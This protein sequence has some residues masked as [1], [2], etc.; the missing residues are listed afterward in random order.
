M[1][2]FVTELRSCIS[3]RSSSS[4]VT[5]QLLTLSLRLLLMMSSTQ[6]E[7]TCSSSSTAMIGTFSPQVI[8]FALFGTVSRLSC[9]TGKKDSSYIPLSNDIIY[10]SVYNTLLIF[11]P[12]CIILDESVS[13]FSDSI[14]EVSQQFPDI[15]D[16]FRFGPSTV[17]FRSVGVFCQHFLN[18]GIGC[19]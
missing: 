4:L 18:Q 14:S 3:D 12:A 16:I 6:L 11:I 2:L 5:S 1:L 15:P 17:K 7:K 10:I 13:S 8:A 9:A 19:N